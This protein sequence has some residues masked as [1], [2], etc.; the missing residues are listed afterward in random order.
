MARWPLAVH[1]RSVVSQGDALILEAPPARDCNTSYRAHVPLARLLEAPP[2]R[3]CNT[4]Y[5]AHVPL[6][7]H[8]RIPYHTIPTQNK[9]YISLFLVYFVVVVASGHRRTLVICEYGS[10][11]LALMLSSLGTI[12]VLSGHYLGAVWA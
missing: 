11:L 10:F 5:R 7:R 8:F 12:W 3:D 9:A 1:T 6:A 2:A 4:S